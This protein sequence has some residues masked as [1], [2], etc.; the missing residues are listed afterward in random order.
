[1]AHG[2]QW[3]KKLSEDHKTHDELQ[4]AFDKWYPRTMYTVAMAVSVTY[5]TLITYQAAHLP[6]LPQLVIYFG[7]LFFCCMVCHGELVRLKPAARY[8]TS[9]Y[10]ATAAGGAAG[11]LFVGLLAPVLF[12][13]LIEL[14]IGLIGCCLFILAA[15]YRDRCGMLSRRPMWTWTCLFVSVLGLV[16]MLNTTEASQSELAVSRNFY[17]VLRVLEEH[18]DNPRRHGRTHVQSAR[19]REFSRAGC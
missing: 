18:R 2:D 3:T 5:A 1:M 19:T 16:R 13:R 17:G 8:L 9:F 4:A 15:Q 14:Q 12:Q 6:I 11:G 7:T 10:L